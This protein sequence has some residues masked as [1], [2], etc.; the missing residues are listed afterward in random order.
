MDPATKNELERLLCEL[1]S[2][3]ITVRQAHRLD[4][5][6]SASAEARAFYLDVMSVE[7]ALHG[8]HTYETAAA[9]AGASVPHAVG[10][11]RQGFGL[12]RLP[13][14]L[15]LAASFLAAAVLSSWFTASVLRS[16]SNAVVANAAEDPTAVGAISATR[17]CRWATPGGGFGD[18]VHRGQRLS[19]QQGVA[20]I[21][22]NAGSKLL[23]EGPSLLQVR[24]DGGVDLIAGRLAIDSPDDIEALSIRCGRLSVADTGVAYG[25][26]AESSGAGEIHVFRGVVQAALLSDLGERVRLCR[27]DTGSGGRLEANDDDL[28]PIAAS[29]GLFVRSLSPSNGMR[30]GLYAMDSFDYG[31]GPLGEQNGGFGWA[32][33]WQD[34]ETERDDQGGSTSLVGERSLQ[35][36]GVPAIGGRTVQHGQ[37]NRVR[38]VLSL[39]INGVLDSS[40]YVEDFDGHRLIGKEGQTIYLAFQQRASKTGDV[41]YGVE[42][43][44]GDGNG[45]RVL[46]IGHGVEQSGYAATSNY[47]NLLDENAAPLGEENTD[48]NLFVIRIDYGEGD[49][50][51]A[52]VFR[53]PVSLVDEALC[54]PTAMLHGN[55][56]FD[57]ISLGNY[58]GSKVHE[59]DDLRVGADFR[60]VTGQRSFIRG[61]LARA[62][63]APDRVRAA[64]RPD[65]KGQLGVSLSSWRTPVLR[66]ARF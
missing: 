39:S 2:G 50:D 19:L 25:L 12:G 45:N 48:V 27:L 61:Q 63:G 21:T 49:A 33:A 4:E 55:F 35:W 23:V 32:G 64:S 18:L 66:P 62:S 38:R 3:D 53:N 20:E 59:V 16:G 40:G 34:L 13:G 29:D 28:R 60:V 54:E 11:R 1:A 26:I 43:N 42:L 14:W 31:A 10:A 15:A 36:P 47:N 7:A 30:D 46:C 65:A 44:R 22:F 58:N 17:N 8:R 51:R 5:L 37:S 9:N 6:V 41:F 52:T 56:S 24:D 57:R